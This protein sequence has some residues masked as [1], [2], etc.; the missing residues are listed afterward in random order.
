[1]VSPFAFSWKLLSAHIS[2]PGIPGR[3][4]KASWDET[5]IKPKS[6]IRYP[7]QGPTDGSQLAGSVCSMSKQ[8][9]L[10]CVNEEWAFWNTRQRLSNN[11]RPFAVS[12]TTIP[13]MLMIIRWEEQS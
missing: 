11:M 7:T 10:E 12:L 2:L 5:G 6:W 4:Q 3:A 13:A 1:M 8:M 9:N